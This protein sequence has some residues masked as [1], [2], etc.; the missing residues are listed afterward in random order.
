MTLTYIPGVSTASTVP[1][2][3]GAVSSD[4]TRLPDK[5]PLFVPSGQAY[6]WSIPWRNDVGASMAALKVGDYADFDTD[7]PN[8]VARW[9]SEENAE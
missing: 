3:A 1:A 8:D 5:T 4:I 2:D 9:L 6:Y 7:D